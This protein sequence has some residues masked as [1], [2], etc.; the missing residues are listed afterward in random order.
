MKKN[1][2]NKIRLGIFVFIGIILFSTGIYFIGDQKQLF[3]TTFSIKGIFK[4]VNGLKIGNN[5]Q[6]SGINVGTVSTIEII[7]DTSVSV[8]M[9]IEE[10][11]RKFIRKNASAIIGAEG[12]MGNKIISI[13]MNIM[14]YLT[15]FFIK[16]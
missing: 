12:L 2:G 14:R 8:N 1:T 6:F 11:T 15:H 5:V 9:T 16:E 4:N 3:S 13:S 7:S 10:G